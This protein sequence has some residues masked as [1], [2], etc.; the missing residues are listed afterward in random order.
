MGAVQQTI[1]VDEQGAVN[2]EKAAIIAVQAEAPQARDWQLDVATELQA[3][4]HI[5][6]NSCWP[7]LGCKLREYLMQHPFVWQ[8]KSGQVIHCTLR[9]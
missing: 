3:G 4:T 9:S 2:V 8:V 7:S 1:I 6:K 5:I